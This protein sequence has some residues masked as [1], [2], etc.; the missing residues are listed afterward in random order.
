MNRWPLSVFNA[1][2]VPFLIALVATPV[3]A[4]EMVFPDDA[5]VNIVSE[6]ME[7][8]GLPLVAYEFASPDDG[9][10]A[11]SFYREYWTHNVDD[12]DTDQ[13]YLETII[14][15]WKV[16]SRLEEGHN[17][18]VQVGPRGLS[19]SQVLVGIS[20]LPEYLEKG[21]K[22]VVRHELPALGRADIV[23]VVTSR[24]NGDVFDSYWLESGDSVERT[25]DYYTA[26]YAKH[27]YQI[28]KKRVV[29]QASRNTEAAMFTAENNSQ[30]I[31][32]DAFNIDDKTRVIATI[33]R[34]G[35]R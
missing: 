34:K 31:R 29:D 25:L 1:F 22:S 28:N 4:L 2:A 5:Q 13:P 6:Q 14:G 12:A 17:I 8:N 9:S 30:S 15:E 26:Y 32:M 11:L 3:H 20:P 23:S 35:S 10:E 7:V 16:L 33:S 18:T 21:V 24:S 19:G 27:H